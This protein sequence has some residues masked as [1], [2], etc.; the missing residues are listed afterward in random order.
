MRAITVSGRRFSADWPRLRRFPGFSRKERRQPLLPPR[1]TPRVPARWRLVFTPRVDQPG[2]SVDAIT[3][4]GECNDGTQIRK[5]PEDWFWVHNRWK[6]PQPNFLLSHYK[7]GIYLPP[8]MTAVNLKPFRIL[9]RGANWLG[10]SIISVPAVRAI[11]AGRP[12][13]HITIAAPEKPRPS[14]SSSPILMKCC[15]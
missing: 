3:W 10:D 11:K 13:A 4:K 12:D 6:T 14:G 8:E 2:D 9:I 7:R 5:A 15:P 1:F